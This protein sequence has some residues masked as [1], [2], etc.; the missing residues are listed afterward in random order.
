MAHI[1]INKIY[2]RTQPLLDILDEAHREFDNLVDD[3]EG[4][5]SDLTTDDPQALHY[6]QDHLDTI[7]DYANYLDNVRADI[8]TVINPLSELL[9]EIEDE[10]KEDGENGY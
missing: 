3:L 2:E 8:E 4:Y 1:D 5:L 9:I 10:L 7:T 6:L